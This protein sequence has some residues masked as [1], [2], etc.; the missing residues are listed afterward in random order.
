[1]NVIGVWK[2]S[3][4]NRTVMVVTRQTG[5]TFFGRY[6]TS[7][8]NVPDSI[9]FPVMGHVTQIGG[10]TRRIAW[11]VCW[12][13]LDQDHAERE[14]HSSV[15]GWAGSVTPA[16]DGARGAAI[17]AGWL[18]SSD[19]SH[20]FRVGDDREWASILAGHD[21]KLW[22]SDDPVPSITELRTM[23]TL[24]EP[25]I[26]GR[27]KNELGSILEVTTRSGSSFTG[28]YI[29]GVGGRAGRGPYPVVGQITL[30]GHPG[31][32]RLAF[33]V[34]YDDADADAD[35]SSVAMFCGRLCSPSVSPHYR[36]SI[37][38]LWLVAHD[39]TPTQPG[40]PQDSDGG[41]WRSKSF[42]RN[43]FERV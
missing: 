6:Y 16:G 36:E 25:P 4:S 13:F 40:R 11:T 42:G 21:A 32:S 37:D 7:K 9:A 26:T 35:R 43:T 14:Y 12:D 22:L 19:P 31:Y 41:E 27:W 10:Q 33:T 38:T 24:K 29:T 8:G 3:V 17:H 2:S 18:L 23:V 20:G 34:C 39:P 1:M 30:L 5:P 15:A 28:T